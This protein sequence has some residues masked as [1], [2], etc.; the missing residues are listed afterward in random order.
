MET[1]MSQSV[2]QRTL[3][4]RIA[5]A[6][7]PGAI[8]T[9]VEELIANAEAA[10]ASSEEAVEVARAQALDPTL[11]A[12]KVQT[13]RQQMEDA[14]FRRDRLRMAVTKLRDRLQ[15]LKAQED[16]E[17]RW[18][19]Y[20]KAKA[21]RDKLVSELKDVYPAYAARLADLAARIKANDREVDRINLRAVPEGAE[22]LR[23][24]ELVARE[25]KGWN[26]GTATVP[27]L[28]RDLR[29]PTFEYDR[30]VLNIWPRS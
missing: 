15:Q 13:A 24:V 4:D 26:D 6:F 2:V 7:L 22:W 25:L 3:D 1:P 17:R 10:A 30:H 16:N 28:V 5:A 27:R 9:D 23:S 18:Q 21:E 11:L 8:S 12:E 14:A 19:A 29:L 20:E